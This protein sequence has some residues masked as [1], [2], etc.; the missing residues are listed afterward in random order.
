MSREGVYRGA[1]QAEGSPGCHGA[2]WG[3]PGLGAEVG[4]G[5]GRKQQSD[6]PQQQEAH[7]PSFLR[8]QPRDIH[9]SMNSLS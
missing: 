2:L 8:A 1:V 5:K 4:G 6:E 3:K 7:H 9:I